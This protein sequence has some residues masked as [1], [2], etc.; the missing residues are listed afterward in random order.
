MEKLSENKEKQ[1]APNRRD[2]LKNLGIGAAGV[3]A[4]SNGLFDGTA[5]AQTPNVLSQNANIITKK[6]PRTGE[7]IPAIGLG[8]FMTFD[9]LPGSPREFVGEVIKRFYDGGGRVLDTSPLYGT[10]EISVGGALN[11]L[12]I[13]KDLFITNKIWS[14]G[15]FLADDSFAQK[16]LEQS[17]GRLWRDKFDA[18]Q[19]HSLVNVDAVVPILK[20]WK[21]QNLIRYIGVTH[22]EVPYFPALA[23]WVEKGEI[24]FVQV[25]Y[26]IAGRAAEE[27]ILPA[28]LDKSVAVLVNMPLE[29]ARLHKLVE[30]RP[31]PDFAKEFGAENWSQFFLKW[32]ISH[33]AVTCAIPATSNPAHQTENI[34]ALKGDLPDQKMRTRMLKYMETVPGFDKLETTAW[35]P[36]KNYNG[37]IRRAQMKNQAK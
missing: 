9:V 26:S 1:N 10:G 37:T 2:F 34:G 3:A 12:G 23:A 6:I 5:R 24:D 30:N 14:T 28:A 4:L 20:N 29:K 21:R 15:E 19:V 31:L 16:S 27:R 18:M 33:P 11:A 22:H 13:A 32:V 7:S 8:S 35:Y 36:D 25:R 17:Q